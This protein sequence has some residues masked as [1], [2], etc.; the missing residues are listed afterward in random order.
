MDRYSVLKSGEQ[1]EW[2]A[3]CTVKVEKYNILLDNQTGQN[4]IQIKYRALGDKKVKSFWVDVYCYDDA[5][6]LITTV[7]DAAYISV[8]ASKG[9]SFGD[10]Q[11]ISVNANSIGNIKVAVKK[12]VFA[13]ESVWRNDNGDIGIILPEQPYAREF[14]GELFNQFSIETNNVKARY[15][16]VLALGENYWQCTCGQGNSKN[17]ENCILCGADVNE[18]AKISDVDY[19]REQNSIRIEK[20]KTVR[21]RIAKVRA[22]NERLAAEKAE[23]ERIAAEERAEKERI[24]AAK[25][26]KKRK[27]IIIT[28]LVSV[29]TICA[30]VAGINKLKHVI[31]YNKAVKAFENAQYD[32]AF[33]TFTELKDYKDSE[34]KA[35]EAEAEKKYVN[36]KSLVEKGDI[37]SLNK[38]ANIYS[39]IN[40]Y[41]DSRQQMQEAKYVRAKK[42]AEKGDISSLKKAAHIYSDLGTYNDSAQQL[43]AIYYNIAVIEYNSYDFE[44]AAS[45]YKLCGNYQNSVQMEIS[46]RNQGILMKAANEY[47]TGNYMNAVGYAASIPG[48]VINKQGIA[49]ANEICE[50]SKAKLYAQATGGK[51]SYTDMINAI[52]LLGRYNYKDCSTKIQNVKNKFAAISG[53][54]Y[55]EYSF[56][57]EYIIS[58]DYRTNKINYTIIFNVPSRDSFYYYHIDLLPTGGTYGSFK[59]GLSVVKLYDGY[60]VDEYGDIYT[61]K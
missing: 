59:E 58:A 30:V 49:S 26:A 42:L 52:E 41:K 12:I 34:D 2:L 44:N 32:E 1:R 9:E 7:S 46:A 13:D 60:I 6:D 29:V 3:G 27:R 17:D 28:A 21:E 39:E 61:K 4:V 35:K 11:P 54:Y 51:M 5:M 40:T 16:K 36:A 45:H 10:R 56:S 24:A 47:N 20:E 22:E 48:V 37:E 8:N 19:L 50:W 14:Y 33:E 31:L 43:K 25:A 15:E 18:L 23:K 53:H 55:G 38:A 57:N